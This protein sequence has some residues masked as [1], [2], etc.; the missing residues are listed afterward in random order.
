M[1]K[2]SFR[3]IKTA[4]IAV[5]F[6]AAFLFLCIET[7]SPA[8][9]ADSADDIRAKITENNQKIQDLQ[10]QIDQYSTLLN[11]TSKEAQ[12][13]SSA[14]KTLELTQKKLETNLA[15]TSQKISKTS[16]TLKQ[17]DDDIEDT[18]I[19]IAATSKAIAESIRD[20][21]FA[22]SQSPIENLLNNKNISATWDYVNAVQSLRTKVKDRY[23]DLSDLNELLNAK[24]DEALGEQSKLKSYQKDLAGQQQTVLATKDEKSKL[25]TATAGKEAEYKKILADKI[26]ERETYEKE[27]FSYE[28]Q[29]KVTLDPNAVPDAKAGILTWPL[30]SIRITQYFGKTV[31]AKR[32][33]VSGTHGGID[34][35]ASIGT[36]V[37]AA[38]SGT[39]A[40]T[41]PLKYKSGCQYGKY[42]LIRHPNGLSTIYG[43]L[44]VVSVKPGDTVITGDVIGYSGDTGYATGPHLH[45]GVYASE[46]IR[47]VDSSA[48][49]SKTCAGIKTVAAPTNAY[50]DPM[51][52]LP[53]L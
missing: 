50:L 26:A 19:K 36:P 28:S 5:A 16:L 35:A 44:S 46:G 20:T 33:Y 15:L 8:S 10:K 52:Y 39:V 51:A 25:L 40:D 1:P 42:V 53:K 9:A 3:N 11:S 27:L 2:H 18:E 48:L 17:L 34:L 47:V 41:E 21:A 30:D 32:L 12:T 6:C 7:A 4:S 24:Q 45:F 29:L 14:L 23:D 37:K 31:A 13:L 38:L 49:G 22:E 43:H